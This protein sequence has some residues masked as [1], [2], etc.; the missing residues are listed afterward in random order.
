[1]NKLSGNPGRLELCIFWAL[2]L[3]LGL[4]FWLNIATMVAIL[5]DGK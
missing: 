4:S 2:V 1:M 3:T 5:F